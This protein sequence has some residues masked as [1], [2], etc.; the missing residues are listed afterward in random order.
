MDSGCRNVAS[1][2]G[3]LSHLSARKEVTN[4]FKWTAYLRSTV[5]VFFA[6]FV[7]LGFGDGFTGLFGPA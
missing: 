1:L 5:I 7:L 6:V 4:F 3:I 2:F